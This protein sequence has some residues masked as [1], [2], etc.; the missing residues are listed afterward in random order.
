MVEAAGSTGEVDCSTWVGRVGG[1]AESY[2][3]G[4]SVFWFNIHFGSE[5]E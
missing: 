4:N 5:E 2:G 1:L 3:E